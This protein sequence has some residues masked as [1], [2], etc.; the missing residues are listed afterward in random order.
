MN[1]FKFLPPSQPQTS[2]VTSNEIP[3]ASQHQEPKSARSPEGS[4]SRGSQE[5]HERVGKSS[6]PVVGREGTNSTDPHEQTNVDPAS[7]S[8]DNMHPST[9]APADHK[10]ASSRLNHAGIKSLFESKVDLHKDVHP[11]G[12]YFGQDFWVTNG[13]M[14]T[15][16]GVFQKVMEEAYPDAMT[17]LGTYRTMTESNINTFRDKA[18]SM[19]GFTKQNRDSFI[20]HVTQTG[21]DADALWNHMPYQIHDWIEGALLIHLKAVYGDPANWPEEVTAQEAKM[22]HDDAIKVMAFQLHTRHISISRDLEERGTPSA[23]WSWASQPNPTI[24]QPAPPQ[25]TTS[26]KRR[27]EDDE[28][29]SEPQSAPK[30]GRSKKRVCL[31]RPSPLK[32]VMAPGDFCTTRQQEAVSYQQGALPKQPGGKPTQ[33]FEPSAKLG[34]ASVIE[35]IRKKMQEKTRKKAEPKQMWEPSS[36]DYPELPGLGA[37]LPASDAPTGKAP[38][39]HPSRRWTI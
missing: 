7:A 30:E 18:L 1:Y 12:N 29:S 2:R 19:L 33:R 35:K 34:E 37:T 26:L 38:W 3:P 31:K 14:S 11:L 20:A 21:S 23:V 16:R 22:A 17:L 27:R 36:T 32:A 10:G 9:N 6:R 28:G 8:R 39:V 15:I 4:H 24:P 13:D 25:N 5:N